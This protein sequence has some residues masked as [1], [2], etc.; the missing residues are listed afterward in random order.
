[1]SAVHANSVTIVTGAAGGVG[2]A[3]VRG[4]VSAGG[5]VVAEDLSPAVEALA[6]DDVAVVVGD[7]AEPSTA[8][9][10]VEVAHTRF[11]RLTGL[12]NNA[13]RFKLAAIEETTV[14]EWDQIM[15]INARGPF[16]HI[17]SSLDALTLSRGAVV[18]TGSMSGLI[19][20]QGQTLYGSTK[21]AVHQLTRMAAIELASRGIRVNAVAPGHISTGFMD[22]FLPPEGHDREA[23]LADIAA[24]HPLGRSTTPEEVAASILFLLSDKAATI[25]GVVLPVDGGY[26]AA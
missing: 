24:Q 8:E 17:K 6:S 14:E 4:L 10:A 19:G 13:A 1:M 11:G 5:K 26:T 2:S 22:D 12:V 23:L 16:I 20:L 3:V 15:R 21:A 18:N 9:R 7:V 25:T